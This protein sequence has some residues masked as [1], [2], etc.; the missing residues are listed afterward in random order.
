MEKAKARAFSRAETLVGSYQSKGIDA[1]I[2]C[3]GLYFFTYKVW[4][5]HN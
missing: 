4:V 1:E 3:S 5:D 2:R